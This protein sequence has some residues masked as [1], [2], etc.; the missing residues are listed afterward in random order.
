MALGFGAPAERAARL[1]D[2]WAEFMRRADP[3]TTLAYIGWWHDK[4]VA[5]SL[6]ILGG[7]VAGIYSV[8]TL[9]EA[10]R[11]GIGAQLTLHPLLQARA[12][13]YGTGVLGASEM[14]VGVYR[15]LGFSEYCWKRTY[16]WRPAS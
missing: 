6:L 1:A 3:A 5:T 8:A 2:A 15:A 4:P 12:R 7:G 10:R 14:G 16:Y 9:P 13:G 11:N